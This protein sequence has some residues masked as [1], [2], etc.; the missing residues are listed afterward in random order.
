MPNRLDEGYA[1]GLTTLAEVVFDLVY[2]HHPSALNRAAGLAG[3]PAL[4]GLH[5]LVH[6]A[7]D[8]LRLMVGVDADPTDL[9]QVC[10]TELNR[11]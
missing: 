7:I 10:L 1:S 8:Q 3:L 4:N 6:Q 9:L 2:T 11:H 5:L